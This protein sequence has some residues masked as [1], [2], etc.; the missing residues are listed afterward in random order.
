MSLAAARPHRSAAADRVAANLG[1]EDE[2]DDDG[3]ASPS[4]ADLRAIQ[5]EERKHLLDVAHSEEYSMLVRSLSERSEAYRQHMQASD[6]LYQYKKHEIPK[7]AVR[8]QPRQPSDISLLRRSRSGG[9]AHWPPQRAF[10]AVPL[11][12]YGKIDHVFTRETRWEPTT[13]APDYIP[14]PGT[15]DGPLVNQKRL[16]RAAQICSRPT[17]DANLSGEE[18]NRGPGCY[19][20][21]GQQP[22]SANFGWYDDKLPNHG[23]G[24]VGR[25]SDD[26]HRARRGIER[27]D[28]SYYPSMPVHANAQAANPGPFHG[29]LRPPSPRPLLQIYTYLHPRR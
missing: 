7:E 28:E 2:D 16:S 27:R 29:Y 15:Y 11:V 26:L 18:M 10:S 5:N 9:R 1:W 24:L 3:A 4:F 6:F 22:A 20:R 21:F 19:H 12:H 13:L 8:S 14:P 23:F 25:N 17:T